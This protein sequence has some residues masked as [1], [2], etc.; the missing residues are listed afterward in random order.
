MITGSKD[1]NTLPGT[2]V[3]ATALVPD[4]LFPQALMNNGYAKDRNKN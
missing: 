3:F 1:D 4:C 2:R